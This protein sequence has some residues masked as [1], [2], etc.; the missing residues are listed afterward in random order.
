MGCS[1]LGKGD[2]ESVPSQG[3]ADGMISGKRLLTAVARRA[4]RITSKHPMNDV[5]LEVTIKECGT[6]YRVAASIKRAE[7]VSITSRTTTDG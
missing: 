1:R 3:A 6:E 5:T 7:K 2:I 4:L